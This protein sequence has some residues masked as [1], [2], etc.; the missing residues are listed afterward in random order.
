ML[1]IK[2][3]VPIHGHLWRSPGATDHPSP[4]F[5]T[6]LLWR[7]SGNIP[8]LE[9]Q[10]TGRPHDDLVLLTSVT[11]VVLVVHLV[12]YPCVLHDMVYKSGREGRFVGRRT[13]VMYMSLEIRG[14]P[15]CGIRGARMYLEIKIHPWN[16]P[17]LECR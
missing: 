7:A 6:P 2:Q 16:C 5:P 10:F 9:G 11:V 12:I 17:A 1:I 13:S 14:E 15:D 4:S 3:K 8:H